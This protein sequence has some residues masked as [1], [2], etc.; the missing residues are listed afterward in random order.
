MTHE[1]DS[2]TWLR[3]YAL[4]GGPKGCSHEMEDKLKAAADR[5]K[6]L[7]AEKDK[8]QPIETAPKD[9][10]EAL[11]VNRFGDIQVWSYMAPTGNGW[12]SDWGYADGEVGVKEHFPTHWQPLPEPPLKAAKTE[13]ER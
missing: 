13:E 4:S 2:Q 3:Q 10:S 5:I 1:I 7:E 12:T 6:E 11:Y 8:W 9:G